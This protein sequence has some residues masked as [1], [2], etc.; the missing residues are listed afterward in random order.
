MY[1]STVKVEYEFKFFCPEIYSVQD[2]TEE[3]REIYEAIATETENVPNLFDIRMYSSN[4]VQRVFIERI[5][6]GKEELL[7]DQ[8]MGEGIV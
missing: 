2:L 3:F 5:A 6:L 1:L 4:L 8:Y 7:D